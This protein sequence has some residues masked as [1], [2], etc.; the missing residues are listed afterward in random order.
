MSKKNDYDSR[1]LTRRSMLR[2]ILGGASVAVGLPALEI[3]LNE[4]GTAYADGSGFPR[5]YGLWYWGNGVWAEGVWQA[6]AEGNEIPIAWDWY[7]RA[8]GPDYELPEQF[9]GLQRHKDVLTIVS[10]TDIQTGSRF[11]HTSGACGVLTGSSPEESA[12]GTVRVWPVP[13]IDQILADHIGGGTVFRSIETSAIQTGDRFSVSYRGPSA[14]NPSESNPHA[15]FERIFGASF[16][17]PGE[18]SVV[19]EDRVGLQ[20]S[21]LDVVMDQSRRLRHRLGAAD[22]RRLEQHFQGVRELEVRLGRLLEDPPVL[23]AC[24]RP[25]MPP[26]ELPDDDRGRQQI[27]VRNELMAELLAM[28]MACDQTR[29]F[30]HLFTKPVGNTRLPLEID[31]FELFGNLEG[32]H[33]LTHDEP[34][35]EDGS[36]TPMW[37]VHEVMIWYFQQLATFVDKFRAIEEGDGTLLDHMALMATTDTSNPRGHW[38]T[39]FPIMYFG[40][41]SGRL[42]QGV[43]IRSEGDNAARVGLSM[44]RACGAASVV[45]F[46]KDAGYTEDGFGEM[47]T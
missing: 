45:G 6:D 35:F 40:N 1:G 27:G 15:L 47:E 20:R 2:G 30:S 11:P 19:D 14:R 34:R 25:E 46:G 26:M 22:K 32:H 13:T 42:Q 12:D 23:D 38:V 16:R 3:F 33:T 4:N 43:H 10:G 28:A 37:R 8:E 17:L 41:A 44:I 29:V 18:E 24:I 21:V 7:P 9:Q 39:N 31:N 36:P 5:R